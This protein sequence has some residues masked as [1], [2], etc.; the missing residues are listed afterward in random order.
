MKL[1]Q[2]IIYIHIYVRIFLLKR[3]YSDNTKNFKC[4]LSN[5]TDSEILVYS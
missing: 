3:K 4:V 5:R 1:V 2:V